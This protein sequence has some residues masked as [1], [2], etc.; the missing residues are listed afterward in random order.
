MSGLQPRGSLDVYLGEQ[1]LGQLE[2]RTLGYVAFAF[3]D[4]AIERYGLGSRVLSVNLPISEGKTDAMMTTP[5]FRGLLPEGAAL[6]RIAS[7]FQVDPGD[8][9]GLLGLIGRESAGA[10]TILAAGEQ[11]P[12]PAAA[13]PPPLTEEELTTAIAELTDKPLGV[14]V[15]EDEVRLSLAGVQDKLPLVE[16]ADGR[17]AHPVRG[18]PSTLIAKPG[19]EAFADLVPNEAFCLA[20]ATELGLPVAGFRVLQ[21]GGRPLLIVERYDRTIDANGRMVRLHQEDVC[22]AGGI[23]PGFKY[24]YAGGPSLANVAALLS[25]HS[26]QP[27]IDRRHLFKLAAVNA[28]LGNCDAHGKN[29][30]LLHTEV[31]VSLAP[32]YDLVSTEAYVHTDRLGMRLGPA[33]RLRNVDLAALVDT[34]RITSGLRAGQPILQELAEQLP[35]ALA[36]AEQRAHTEGWHVA[37]VTQIAN[38][39]SARAARMLSG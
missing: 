6:D 2:D 31:G 17:L 9:W 21:V 15:E 22:Q 32:A 7:E 34:S 1:L 23:N 20:V 13:P 26:F 18:Q 33:E 36:A 25:D 38:D 24:E 12:A 35:G 19:K 29:L 3:V 28:L 4:E 5:F 37:R 11:L 27:G 39:T 8:T 30:S 10:L 14:T 16:L